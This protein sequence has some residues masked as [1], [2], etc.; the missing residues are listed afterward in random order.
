MFKQIVEEIMQQPTFILNPQVGP[1]EISDAISQRLTILRSNI[2]LLSL[3][4]DD[5]RGSPSEQVLI[6]CLSGLQQWL[7]EVSTLVLLRK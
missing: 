1:V 2:D 7:E 5:E 6:D 3:S 4:L